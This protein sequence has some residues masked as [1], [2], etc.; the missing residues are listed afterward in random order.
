M[1]YENPKTNPNT[2]TDTTMIAN[3]VN[4]ARSIVKFFMI[5]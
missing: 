3:T 4:C 2:I 5:A 1:N